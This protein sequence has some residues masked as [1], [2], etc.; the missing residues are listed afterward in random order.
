MVDN[1][2]DSSSPDIKKNKKLKKAI[3][4]SFSNEPDQKAE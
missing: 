2:Y 3:S 1:N 4:I